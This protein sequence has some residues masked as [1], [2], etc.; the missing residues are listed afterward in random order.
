MR[1][2]E[3]LTSLSVLWGQDYC[4]DYVVVL[5]STLTESYMYYEAWV[6]CVELALLSPVYIFMTE[7][8]TARE[9]DT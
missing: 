7:R 8:K 1:R 4:E 3:E 2:G 6:H 9:E 5:L